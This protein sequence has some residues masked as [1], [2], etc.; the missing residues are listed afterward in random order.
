MSKPSNFAVTYTIKNEEKILP[1]V[2]RLWQLL[3]CERVYIFFDGT[4]DNSRNIAR[5]HIFVEA[6]D[7]IEP[8]RLADRPKWIKEIEGRWSENMDVRKRINTY[9]AT[10]RASSQGIEWVLSIDP[11]E[12]VVP[13]LNQPLNESSIARFLSK[14]PPHVDQV[15]AQNLEVQATSMRVDNPFSDCTVFLRRHPTTFLVHRLMRAVLL[16]AK[17]P[18]KFV[19]RVSNIIYQLRFR[20]VYL[21]KMRDPKTGRSIPRGHFLGYTNYKSFVRAGSAQNLMHNVHKWQATDSRRVT[22]IKR[23]LTLHYDFYDADV[24]RNKFIQRPKINSYNGEFY[25]SE[26]ARMACEYSKDDF[27]RFFKDSI[28]IEDTSFVERLIS[29][30]IC[31]SVT[32]IAE[33]FANNDTKCSPQPK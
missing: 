24:A 18:L 11:D 13:S 19:A 14:I 33:L 30:R 22:S 4:T 5:E 27:Y 15:L 23:G 21:K 12:V 20:G 2:L 7:S 32:S 29:R 16:R 25:R 10:Q 3:G 1:Y 8:N 26:I 28:M 9:W 6:I 31:S 17:F